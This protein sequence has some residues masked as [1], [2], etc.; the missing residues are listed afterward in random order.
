MCLRVEKYWKARVPRKSK[1]SKVPDSDKQPL[2]RKKGS[3]VKDAPPPLSCHCGAHLSGAWKIWPTS[4]FFCQKP[5]LVIPQ[6]IL[7]SI[8]FQVK[9]QFFLREINLFLCFFATSKIYRTEKV[10]GNPFNLFK[11]IPDSG[12]WLTIA[13]PP[14]LVFGNSKIGSRPSRV[15]DWWKHVCLKIEQL[16]FEVTLATN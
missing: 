3:P 1:S 6:L 5:T 11:S 8:P 14:K 9:W 15:K 4:L 2:K 10:T 12:K 16:K 13:D 7:F